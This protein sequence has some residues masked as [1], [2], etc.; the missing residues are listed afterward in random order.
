EADQRT[1]PRAS[2]R[3]R[4][5]GRVRAAARHRSAAALR[6]P[7]ARGRTRRGAPRRHDPPAGGRAA[8]RRGAG[9]GQRPSRRLRLRLRVEPGGLGARGRRRHAARRLL[10][11]GGA[12]PGT[13]LRARLAPGAHPGQL[14]G[15][16]DR[17]GRN[18]GGRARG[19]AGGG[20]GAA[21]GDHGHGGAQRSAHD[22]GPQRLLGQGPAGRGGGQL[23]RRAAQRAL[24]GGG[25]GRAGEPARQPE[26]GGADQRARRPHARRPARPVPPAAPGQHGGPRG[27]D[28]QPLRQ[29]RSGGDGRHRQHRPQGQRGAGPFRRGHGE[30]RHQRPLQRLRQPG[31]PARAHDALRQPGPLWRRTADERLQQPHEPGRRRPGRLPGPALHRE[32]TDAVAHPQHQ[33]GAEAEQDQ[34]HRQHADGERARLPPGDAQRLHPLRRRPQPAPGLGRP[35]A[36]DLGRRDLRW[37][38]VVQ[39]RD[40]AAPE[41]GVGGGAL[42]PLRVRPGERLHA[43][44]AGRGPQPGG[45]PA[46]AH[47]EPDG[48]GEQRDVPAG[49]PHPDG[50]GGAGGD[51]VQGAASPGGQRPHHRALLVRRQRLGQHGREQPVQDRRAGARRLRGVHAQHREAGAAGRGARGAH[52]PRHQPRGRR[53]GALHRPLPQRAGRLQRGCRAPGEGEL[54]APHPA[55]ADAASQLVPLL[56]GPAQP[57]PRQPVPAPGVHGRVRAGPAAERPAGLAAAHALLPAHHGR[58]PPRPHH[59][60]RHHHLHGGQ[61]LHGGLVRR[62]RQRLAAG[63]AADGLRGAERLPP[64]VGRQHVG[65]G[66]VELRPGLV[67][68]RQRQPEA[69]QAHGRVGVR[70]V[71]RADE[72]GV[73]PHRG[74]RHDQ[75]V[76]APE[77]HER[78]GQRDLPRAGPVQH[79]ALPVLHG[80]PEWHPGLPDGHG[81]AVRRA[82]GVHL[83]QLQLRPDAAPAHSLA[84]AAA[85]GPGAADGR[86]L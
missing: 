14:V 79:H 57:L 82:R 32:R 60:G 50:A 84:A 54:L 56:R 52:R 36:H 74:L 48:R 61:H 37:H 81:A 44:A 42:Q 40:P 45:Q 75:H 2:I 3:M 59:A 16:H 28:P 53:A 20:G 76:A 55:P 22:R 4:R 64:G 15:H 5:P 43:A 8:S 33:R 71:P 35:A 46:A 30:R 18:L 85:V 83:L 21:G 69:G 68:A 24:G 17:A 39:E 77:V 6:R 10:P 63:R 73:R 12:A 29:V 7:G 72:H 9:R 80:R 25:P 27:G 31:V 11:R 38:A 13:L 62:G 19:A 51:G 58:H 66:G 65:G 70:D 26:R 47:A 1:L 34:L 41:R 86:A 23:H 49:R 78:Q 67:H